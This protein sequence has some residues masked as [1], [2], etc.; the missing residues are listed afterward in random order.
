MHRIPGKARRQ[1]PRLGC[2]ASA[3]TA[4]ALIALTLLPLG[5]LAQTP[6]ELA[7]D[8]PA[9]AGRIRFFEPGRSP[10]HVPLGVVHTYRR[11]GQLLHS[12][13]EDLALKARAHGGDIVAG[14]I[15]G[16]DDPLQEGYA[17]WVLGIA[18]RS[19]A[20]GISGDTL[21]ACENCL[22]A[23]QFDGSA[24]GALDS[25]AL[26]QLEAKAFA[27]ARLK[28]AKRGYYLIAAARAESHTSQSAAEA[29]TVALA[30]AVSI[31]RAP[32][33]K[34]KDLLAFNARIAWRQSDATFWHFAHALQVPSYRVIDYLGSDRLLT[35]NALSGVYSRLPSLYEDRDGDGVVDGRDREPNTPPGFQVDLVGRTLDS[36][37]DGVPNTIDDQPFTIPKY[38]LM[39]GERGIPIVTHDADFDG[40]PDAADLCDSTNV[41]YVVDERGCPVEEQEIVA[42]LVDRGVL[43]ERRLLFQTNEAILLESSTARLDS[44]GTALSG[45]PELR[46]NIDG[47]CDDRGGDALNQQLSERRAAAVIDYLLANFPDLRREQFKANGYGKTR[48]LASDVDEQSRQLN[49]RVE[50][51]VQ[52]PEDA[53]RHV[54][55]TRFRL[56]N[57]AVDGFQFDGTRGGG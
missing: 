20:A 10:S 13:Y 28:L 49:R 9:A 44:L 53:V 25:T 1:S 47:H 3:A 12:L 24:A 15:A 18:A 11:Q 32:A 36:D 45:L 33:E 2:W 43:R 39:V 23:W 48:P 56:R 55:G 8:I 51:A 40:I 21:Q 46:F 42:V 6:T 7:T 26:A 37:G 29:D 14:V 30:L 31:S 27:T 22:V 41:R 38:R 4:G 34:S 19:T 50:I 57:E 17:I 54:E 5:S 16:T 35:H 52:N